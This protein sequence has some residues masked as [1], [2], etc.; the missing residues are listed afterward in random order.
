MGI[1]TDSREEVLPRVEGAVGRSRYF[2]GVDLKR[3]T[4]EWEGMM[5]GQEKRELISEE[6][7]EKLIAQA[8]GMNGVA[9][10][11]KVEGKEL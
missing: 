6:E 3:E 10:E 4:G 2:G 1:T 5:Q 7:L 9:S 11:T 8:V